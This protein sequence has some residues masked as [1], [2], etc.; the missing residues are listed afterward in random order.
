MKLHILYFAHDLAD[1]AIRRRVL[2]LQNGGARVTVAGFQRGKS[3]LTDDPEVRAISLGRTQDARFAQRIGAVASARLSLRTKLS[4]L[5]VPDVIIA[6]N[7]ETLALAEAAASLFGT[8]IPI[9]YECLDIHRLLLDGGVKGKFMRRAEGYFGRNARLLITSS[10]AFVEHYFGPRSRL[11][12]PVMLLENKVLD[13]GGPQD[14]VSCGPRLP[15]SGVPWRI[16]WFGAL[17]CR[18][19]LAMLCD[20]DRKST[21]LNSSHVKISYAVF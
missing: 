13:L 16:G 5:D 2:M 14:V 1:A 6:R 17:R 8:G 11:D 12:L 21:R 19:S 15:D 9:V 3:V 7:L 4:G 10:P 20:L 18:R